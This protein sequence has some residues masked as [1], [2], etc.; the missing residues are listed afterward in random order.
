MSITA[1]LTSIIE[2]IDELDAE[3]AMLYAEGYNV[4]GDEL[5]D[6]RGQLQR[7]LDAASRAILARS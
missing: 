7:L 4:E 2:R 1:T 3:I 5:L 6:E